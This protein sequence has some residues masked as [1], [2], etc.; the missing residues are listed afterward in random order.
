MKYVML[1]FLSFDFIH[2][3]V[4]LNAQ[5]RVLLREMDQ[6]R[7]RALHFAQSIVGH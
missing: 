2:L 1:L 4:L 5:M 7:Q 3:N 6:Q